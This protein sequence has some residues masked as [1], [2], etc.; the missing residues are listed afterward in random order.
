M[1]INGRFYL[2]YYKLTVIKNEQIKY[3]KISEIFS[4]NLCCSYRKITN[5][6]FKGPHEILSSG[7]SL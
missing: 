1:K 4:I 5:I 7:C 2:K 3:T 6:Y